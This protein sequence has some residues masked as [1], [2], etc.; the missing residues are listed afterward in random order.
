MT[1]DN[2]T[3]EPPDID[4]PDIDLPIGVVELAALKVRAVNMLNDTSAQDVVEAWAD[5]IVIV[6]KLKQLMINAELQA[7]IEELG[8]EEFLKRIVG[9]NFSLEQ[10]PGTVPKGPE[11]VDEV[12]AEGGEADN[13]VAFTPN[14]TKLVQDL[15]KDL[16]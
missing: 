1:S 12:L 8:P 11:W 13:V 2:T 3:N 14:P 6:N 16:K 9:G 10:E 7:Q 5:F 4:F 15:L